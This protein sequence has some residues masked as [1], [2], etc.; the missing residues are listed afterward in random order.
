MHATTVRHRSSPDWCV[1]SRRPSSK[2]TGISTASRG[3]FA[4]CVWFVRY[5]RLPFEALLS[6]DCI[7]ACLSL[8]VLL[9]SWIEL[10]W[11]YCIH[12]VT[13]ATLG[14]S[15][16]RIKKIYGTQYKAGILCGNNNKSNIFFFYKI[17]QTWNTLLHV[18]HLKWLVKVCWLRSILRQ[19]GTLRR[20]CIK[21][22]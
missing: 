22:T 4:Y 18:C 1:G 17:I 2:I 6:L 14:L 3:A 7:N 16:L 15:K 21:I 12:I 20:R 5:S 9:L 8:M 10:N 13:Y 19:P 11:I